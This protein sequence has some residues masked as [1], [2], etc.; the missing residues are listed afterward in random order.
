[1]PNILPSLF[2]LF[3]WFSSPL[4]YANPPTKR[5]PPTVEVQTVTQQVLSQQLTAL[6]VLKAQ[7]S[8]IIKPEVS[9]RV[10][11]INFNEGQIVKQNQVLIQLDDDL[12][13]A[14]LATYQASLDL[15]QTEYQRYQALLKEQQ[16]A[17]LDYE[18]KKA[19]LAQIKASMALVQA[20]IR[21]RQIRAP[22]T[23]VIGLRQFSIG[24]VLQAN[25]SLVRLNKMNALKADI[26]IPESNSQVVTLKQAVNLQVDSLSGVSLKGYVAAIEPSLDAN[27][28]ALMVRVNIPQVDSRVRDGMTARANF[29]FG[30][31]AA[32]VI[33][34]QALVAQG[35]K[36][37]VFVVKANVATA[38]VVSLGKRQAG[39]VEIRQG[40][41]V[42]DVIVVS[43]QNK[44]SKP[45]MPIKAIS[46]QGV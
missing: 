3:I 21:Q 14:E 23:G 41:Q 44:L 6:A 26:K 11:A 39:K 36:L 7:E 28:R 40:L 32:I 30:Q 13:Q 9:G 42:G 35:G 16:V 10:T 27:T 12:L 38:Q 8:I 34:E 45:Q 5:P 17:V 24:D 46:V 25:Q 19:E 37:V 22:F 31:Q 1:M 2:V 33:P 15:A 29:V 43:G 4:I 18:R 20:K